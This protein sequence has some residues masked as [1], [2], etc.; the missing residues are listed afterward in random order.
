VFIRKATDTNCIAF[1]LNPRSTA[2]EPTI[3]H[4]RTSTTL[5]PTIY[6]TR[7]PDLQHSN[8][9]STTL[10]PT[11]YHTRTHDLPHSNPRSMTLGRIT[12]IITPPMLK[13]SFLTTDICSV[14]V[15]TITSSYHRT[16]KIHQH[17]GI[18]SDWSV[19]YISYF[20]CDSSIQYISCF[21]CDS[22]V[23][24]IYHVSLETRR[25]NIY[26]VSLVTRRSN[27]FHIFL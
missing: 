11:I 13:S 12:L 16:V 22:S 14:V 9:R 24:Y 20:S 17:D 23:Q 27:I 19:Q 8:P 2:L 25:P 18:T 7:I 26:H 15:V 1:G 21:S 10:E 6:H 3:Y 4:T 5:E